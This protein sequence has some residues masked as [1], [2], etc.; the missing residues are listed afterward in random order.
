MDFKNFFTKGLHGTLRPTN[1][2]QFSYKN[3]WKQIYNQT[4]LDEWHVGDFMSAEYTIVVDH[5][6]SDKEVLKVIVV[7][8]PNDAGITVFGRAGTNDQLVN[9]SAEVT[10]STFKLILSPAQPSKAGARAMFSASYYQ[11]LSD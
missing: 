9:V 2:T 5:T 3:N 8:S 1:N 11:T 4:I 7:A 10:E 6:R